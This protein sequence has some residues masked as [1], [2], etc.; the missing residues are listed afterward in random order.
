MQETYRT[1]TNAIY[2]S[3][4]NSTVDADLNG[5]HI[6]GISAQSRFWKD[7]QNHIDTGGS[8]AAYVAPPEPDP[9]QVELEQLD[10]VMPRYAEDIINVLTAEQQ[11]ALPQVAR[12]R[13]ARKEQLRARL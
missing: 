1:V 8:I 5:K 6:S 7:I 11:A 2:T 13:K 4:D 12:D 3:A 10:K 9:V